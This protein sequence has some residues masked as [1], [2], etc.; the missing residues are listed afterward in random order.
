MCTNVAAIPV[1]SGAVSGPAVL[2]GIVVTCTA[3]GGI[4]RIY[5]NA[6]TNSGTILYTVSLAA[7][8]SEAH[9]FPGSGVQARNGLFVAISAGTFEGSIQIA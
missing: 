2:A 6:S 8:A 1:A 9:V 5:D 4:L 7:N 3:T